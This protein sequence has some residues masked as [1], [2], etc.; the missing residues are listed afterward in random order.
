MADIEALTAKMKELFA[1]QKAKGAVRKELEKPRDAAMQ[2]FE[3]LMMDDAADKAAKDAA[4]VEMDAAHKP[5]LYYN[6][7]KEEEKAQA[8]V[9]E[10][11]KA[12]ADAKKASPND[13]CMIIIIYNNN[14]MTYV[15]ICF[16]I[17]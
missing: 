4:E 15:Y 9:T 7:F 14:N 17:L 6:A 11:M 10:A 3:E 5:F 1:E 16:F 2:K 13:T 12:L 8:A